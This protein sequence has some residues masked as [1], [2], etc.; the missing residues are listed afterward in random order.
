MAPRDTESVRERYEERA[1]GD[2][3]LSQR[4]REGTDSGETDDRGRSSI[5]AQLTPVGIL[6]RGPG[7][8]DE[9]TVPASE[10][11]AGELVRAGRRWDQ[12]RHDRLD[13][14]KAITS[15]SSLIRW[16]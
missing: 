7:G 16:V 1:R 13:E 8:G 12:A 4:K 11:S 14:R 2:R 3:S 5:P 6:G 9:T 10:P 15:P